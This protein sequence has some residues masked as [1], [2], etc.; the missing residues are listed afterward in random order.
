MDL[1][2]V[3]LALAL[4]AIVGLV[5]ALAYMIRYV[6]GDKRRTEGDGPRAEDSLRYPPSTTIVLGPTRRVSSRDLGLDVPL[7][8]LR[9][10][11]PVRVQR[12]VDPLWAESGWRKE[13]KAIAGDYVAGRRRF[14]GRIETPHRGAFM[15]Y[16]WDPPIGDL[17]RH[18][19]RVCF[20]PT[21]VQGRYRV[22]FRTTPSSYDHAIASIEQ[23]LR[24]ATGTR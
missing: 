3:V 13:G 19:H 23:V 12:H 11:A 2:W 6:A 8:K 1:V 9:R 5:I 7:G 15:A 22:H 14:R 24:E 17:A 18:P 10:G 16:I 4:M 21:G 20:Q